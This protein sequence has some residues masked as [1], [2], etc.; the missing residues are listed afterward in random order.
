MKTTPFYRETVMVLNHMHLCL[1]NFTYSWASINN[2]L[3]LNQ[4]TGTTDITLISDSVNTNQIATDQ[5]SIYYNATQLRHLISKH[6]RKV[7]LS[8]ACWATAETIQSLKVFDLAGTDMIHV[9]S[10]L[11]KTKASTRLCGCPGWSASLSPAFGRNRPCHYVAQ[12]IHN[13]I[14]EWF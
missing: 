12:F 5:Y 6:V 13:P 9:L 11:Q 8:L 14:M 2:V 7:R 3:F 4:S 1:Q 10:R